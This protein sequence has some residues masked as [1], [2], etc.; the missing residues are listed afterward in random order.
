M[1]GYG[2]LFFVSLR[3]THYCRREDSLIGQVGSGQGRVEIQGYG[4]HYRA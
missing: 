1:S 2:F 3:D 4:W